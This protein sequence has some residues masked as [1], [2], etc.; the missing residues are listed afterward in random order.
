M[1]IISVSDKAAGSE[2]TW[3]SDEIDRKASSLQMQYVVI[4][5]S[6]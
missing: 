2:M 4:S 1:F 3:S 6:Q 5:I